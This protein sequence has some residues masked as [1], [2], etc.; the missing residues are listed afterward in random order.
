MAKSRRTVDHV[1]DAAREVTGWLDLLG[2]NCCT[3]RS[4]RGMDNAKRLA[5]SDEAAAE[6]EAPGPA[7]SRNAPSL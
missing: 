2:R 7:S 4:Y 6:A 3:G 1:V 5:G